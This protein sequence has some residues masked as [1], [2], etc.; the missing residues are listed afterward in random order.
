M[1]DIEEKDRKKLCA[2]IGNRLYN[3]RVNAGL[4]QGDAAKLGNTYQQSISEAEHGNIF[5][6]PDVMYRLCQAYG[7]S[8]DYL[9]SGKHIEADYILLDSRIVKLDEKQL[10]NLTTIVKLFIDSI[11]AS[12]EK[13]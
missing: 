5:H 1:N 10:Q 6:P 9:I 8:C 7:I 11:D 3:A 4:S 12:K 2:E 13:R